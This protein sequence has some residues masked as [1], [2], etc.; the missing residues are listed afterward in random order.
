M[1]KSLLVLLASLTMFSAN[2]QL[3]K[4]D[5]APPQQPP[6]KSIRAEKPRAQ[7]QEMQMR[8]PGTAAFSAAPKR[9]SDVKVWYRRPAGAFPA[10][11]VVEDGANSGTLLSPYLHIKPYQDYTF[12]GFAEGV[13]DQ[14]GYWW[15]VEYW[16]TNDDDTGYEQDRVSVPGKNLIWQWGIETDLAPA[17]YVSEPD[18]LYYW[19]H[20]GVYATG[21]SPWDPTVV[22]G[23]S[24]RRSTILSLP[25]TMDTWDMEFLESSK[26]MVAKPGTNYFYTC[27]SGLEPYPSNDKGWWFGK[28]G[29]HYKVEDQYFIDGIAQAFEKPTAPYLLK[30]VVLNCSRL[31]VIGQVD[32]TCKIYKLD[33]IPAYED[34]DCATLPEEPGE[35]IAFGRAH[36]TPE[37]N[38]MTGGLVF[39][40]LFGEEDGLEFDITPTIDCAILV[41]IDGYND[42]EMANLQNF[43]AMIASN[44]EDDEGF[45]EL[46]YLKFGTPDGNGGV[47]YVWTGLNNFF[48]SGTMKTGFS[49][50]ITA[51]MP[52]LTFNLFNEDG[53]YTF[54]P[55]G[56]S[57]A[58][59]IDVDHVVSGIEFWSYTPSADDY[60][61]LSCK[62]GDDLSDWLEIELTDDMVGGE[63]TGIVRAEVYADP[64]PEGVHYREAIVRF[65]FPGAYL[66]YMFKQGELIPPYPPCPP[67]P[68]GPN[69]AT[70][71]Y[72]INLIL[73]GMYDNCYDLNNDG[74]LTIADVNVI[75][76]IIL[77]E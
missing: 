62:N 72:M 70:V 20:P 21:T 50:F 73:S 30:Q 55:E 71:N 64:L 17:F 37:T 26:T 54:P 11:I 29:N 66:D 59:P 33:E 2:A 27:Y 14:A 45:G 5:L 77:W 65:A 49:I 35:L 12:L 24:D 74:E 41:V 61:Y 60:W 3:K 18:A 42:P 16:D 32:M 52:Y 39:F 46:A 43:T 67:D 31:E 13:S 75:I 53:E 7:V 69:I 63:F 34:N 10:S 1:M 51:D 4:S 6:S 68:E 56:G 19:W 47:N 38:D 15:D 25:S 28:N 22:D 8:V 44:I 23:S 58:K 9:A 57:M 40:T 76:D 48:S 36:L